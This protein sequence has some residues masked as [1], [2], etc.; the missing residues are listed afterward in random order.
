MEIEMKES[1]DF[2]PIQIPDNVYEAEVVDIRE[3]ELEFGATVAIGFK[4][5]E[6]EYAD[7][8]VSGLA[9]KN[10]TPK[11]K[12]GLWLISLGFEIEP[13]KKF[14]MNDLMGRKARILTKAKPRVYKEKTISASQVTE[15]LPIVPEE[16][17][18]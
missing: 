6:G 10:I 3:L 9:S 16:K 2:E 1:K 17:V 4:I 13:G 18:D 11:T 12:L 15:V 14:E 7:K 5:T 8:V